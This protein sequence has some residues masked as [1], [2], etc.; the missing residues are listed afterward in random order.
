MFNNYSENQ[1]ES[2]KIKINDLDNKLT[3]LGFGPM[4]LPIIASELEPAKKKYKPVKNKQTHKNINK[5]KQ[6]K[7][8]PAK[9]IIFLR[10]KIINTLFNL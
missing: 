1:R 4:L 10:K 6:T 7:K 9:F 2:N 3:Y 5:L 8:I